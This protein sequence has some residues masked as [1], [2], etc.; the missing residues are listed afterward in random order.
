[1]VLGEGCLG[2]TDSDSIGSAEISGCQGSNTGL[3]GPQNFSLLKKK[4]SFLTLVFKIPLLHSPTLPLLL[5]VSSQ[6]TMQFPPPHLYSYCFSCSNATAPFLFKSSVG[7]GHLSLC[8]L[9]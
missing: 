4:A 9:P 1:M 2:E 5:I 6:Q 7:Q 8:L 3:V